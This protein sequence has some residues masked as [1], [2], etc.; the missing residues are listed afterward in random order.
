MAKKKAKEKTDDDLQREFWK[1]NGG[2][3]GSVN[4]GD[5]EAA[6]ISTNKLFP[7]LRKLR[8]DTKVHWGPP[9]PGSKISKVRVLFID[10]AASGQFE[11]WEE[12]AS[13]YSIDKIL[14]TFDRLGIIT[15]TRV[16]DEWPTP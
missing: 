7:L 2:E 6:N 11:G 4:Y 14:R 3:F 1:A 8:K 13:L 12:D 15:Y 9:L 5:T 10:G 16:A